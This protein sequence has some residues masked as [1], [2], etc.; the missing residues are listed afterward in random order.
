MWFLPFNQKWFYRENDIPTTSC[1]LMNTVPFFGFFFLTFL[2]RPWEVS[3]RVGSRKYRINK[4]TKCGAI[5]YSNPN[6]LQVSS[7]N[8]ITV[9]SYLGAKFKRLDAVVRVV[10]NDKKKDMVTKNKVL[11]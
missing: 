1:F 10:S 8:N 9:A 4:Y 6:H 7:H 5:N 2:G 11:K 3:G